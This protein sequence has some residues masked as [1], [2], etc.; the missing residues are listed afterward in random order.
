[1]SLPDIP[2]TPREQE[3]LSQTSDLG[4]YDNVESLRRSSESAKGGGRGRGSGEVFSF[5]T[6]Q[7]G[8]VSLRKSASSSVTSSSSSLQQPQ[9]GAPPPKPPLP[10]GANNIIPKYASHVF[11]KFGLNFFIWC[12]CLVFFCYG[13]V[14]FIL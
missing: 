12:A 7:E 10:A 1:V 9:L 3:I 13:L 8:V 6:P 4:S 5:V 11:F 2:L 14:V